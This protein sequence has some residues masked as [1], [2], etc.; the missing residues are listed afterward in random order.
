MLATACH[1]LF[2]MPDALNALLAW[3]GHKA[4]H[5]SDVAPGVSTILTSW[6]AMPSGT[7][8]GSGQAGGILLPYFSKAIEYAR[9][10]AWPASGLLFLVSLRKKRP[11]CR[12]MP[13]R[14]LLRLPGF[15]LTI[16]RS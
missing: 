11:S 7:A 16:S 3:A 2:D 8:H 12:R 14:W 6:P 15:W 5:V 13:A 9:A 1:G 10:F 4:G